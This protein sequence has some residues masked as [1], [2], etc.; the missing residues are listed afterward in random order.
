MNFIV[1][2]MRK[3]NQEIK[4]EQSKQKGLEVI[5]AQHGAPE[6]ID[7]NLRNMKRLVILKL[8]ITSMTGKQSGKW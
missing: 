6:L 8:R 1:E 4:D 3:T 2:A 7:F 5:M